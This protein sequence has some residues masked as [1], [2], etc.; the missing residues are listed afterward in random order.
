MAKRQFELTEDEIAALRQTEQRTRDVYELRRLQAVRLYGSGV[1]TH[2]IAEVVGCGAGSPRQ[3]AMRYRARGI[4]GLRSHWQG[5]N[6]NKLTAQQRADL[7]VRLEQYRPDQVISAEARI[8]RGSFWSVSD[9]RIV[10]QQWYGVRYQSAASY[11][12]LLRQSRLSY[13]K[14]ERVYRSQPS[15]AQVAEFE[16]QLEKK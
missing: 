13:Q 16:Q 10:V 15:A 6:A 1:S 4:E 8:E 11:R 5:G 3:W 14:V 7:A 9:L 2:Q 12:T